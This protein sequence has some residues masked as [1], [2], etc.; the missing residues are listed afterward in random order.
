MSV[1]VHDDRSEGSAAPK[2]KVVEAKTLHVLSF[3]RGQL[4]DP[5]DNCHPGRGNSQMRGQSCA[6]PAT[7]GQANDLQGLAQPGR[8]LCPRGHQVGKSFGEHLAHAG[9][10]ITKEFADV[11]D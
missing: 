6:E 7:D 5:T 9:D 10:G 4:H 1:W 3:R 2:G 8:Q 11:Q